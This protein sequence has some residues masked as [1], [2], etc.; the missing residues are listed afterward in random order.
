MKKI[1][2]L[3]V[4]VSFSLTTHAQDSGGSGDIKN[5]RFGGTA[6]PAITWY[7]PDELKKFESDG[8]VF[9]FGVLINGEW[10]FSNNFAMGFGLG[11]GSSGGKI[12]F[13]D[14][15]HYFFFDDAIVT[16]GDTGTTSGK[17]EHFLLKSRV[18][19][20]SYYLLP[21][22]LKMR[23]NEIGYIRYFFEPRLNI[24]IRKKVRSDD[25]TVNWGTNNTGSQENLDITKDM[26]FLR[27][28]VTLSAGGE[29]YVSGSTAFVFAI[30][31]DYGLSNIVEKESDYL[32]RT[33]SNNT[34]PL[35]QKF[36]QHGL[37][38]SLGVLF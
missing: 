21:I 26:S 14:S 5:F 3:L 9:R 18:Y 12:R 6:L 22:S 1:L 31:Y 38:L 23:T 28:S 11:L 16:P 15:T 13:I 30:G 7:K 10:S 2:A 27:M 4:T 37:V 35:K 8:A 29:Y 36:I 33:K 24:G 34:E 17:D 20:A 32:L 25:A 19:K